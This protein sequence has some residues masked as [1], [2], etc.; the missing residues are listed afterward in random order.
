[1][2]A[3]RTDT[4]AAIAT[5]AGAGGIG[6]VRVSGKRVPDIAV[7]LLGKVPKARHAHLLD[8][9]DAAGHSIDTGLLLLFPAP[10]SFTGEDVMELQ[11]HGSR[12][13]L[14]MALRRLYELGARPA[15]A[16]EFSERA[17]LNG[18]LDLTQA[19]AI[20]DLINA[21]SEA[22]ARAAQRSLHGVFS[23]QVDELAAAVLATR[24]RIEAAIDFGDEDIPAL[25][26]TRLIA[27]L[28]EVETR[29][30]RLIQAAERG[31]RLNDGLHVV[32]LGQPNVGK[33][34][35]LN[36]LVADERAIVTDQAGTTRDL[37][38]EVLRIDGA[39][40]T[41]VDTAG[42][43]DASDTV[44]QEGIRRALFEADRAD[45]IIVVIDDTE[46]ATDIEAASTTARI[47]VH[48][49]ID[50]CGQTPRRHWMDGVEHIYL[51]ARSG[52]GLELLRESLAQRSGA[53]EAGSFS[54]RQ[55][56]VLALERAYES[57]RQAVH[58][59]A[60]SGSWELAAEDLRQ[61]H[62]HLGEITGA[63]STED[64]LGQIF[65]NFC[66]GK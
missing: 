39:E 6:V 45:V 12:P 61:A 65:A 62:D 31:R 64:L 9:C 17:F 15:R 16:G 10:A 56:H 13:S 47:V 42:L 3:D 43:R 57:V 11:L 60:G 19:E 55:R 14:Q 46:R 49:K 5:A 50:L 33:S 20:A 48:N 2:A 38:R 37:L 35:L 34:S 66:I 58:A 36:A 29:L 8:L 54:A 53:T 26:T 28:T 24:V 4:I 25:S 30:Q 44:E 59:M 51:S 52:A 40:L 7:R 63:V 21:S 18:K 23:R 32:I 22:A 27:S 41:L 1:M